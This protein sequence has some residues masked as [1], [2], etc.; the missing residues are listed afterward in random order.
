MEAGG[1]LGQQCSKGIGSFAESKPTA[2]SQ[3]ARVKGKVYLGTAAAANSSMG[4]IVD[5]KLRIFSSALL[6]WNRVGGEKKKELE[7]FS[8]T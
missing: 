3:G 4:P 5:I 1:G 8:G 6:N 2:G 7:L